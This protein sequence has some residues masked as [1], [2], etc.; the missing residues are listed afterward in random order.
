MEGGQRFVGRRRRTVVVVIVVVAAANTS[1]RIAIAI[2]VAVGSGT[3]VNLGEIRVVRKFDQA[4][5]ETEES[6]TFPLITECGEEGCVHWQID[7]F[8]LFDD[9]WG[10][11]LDGYYRGG[12]GLTCRTTIVVV[13]AVI[14]V[15]VVAV[16]VVRSDG[17]DELWWWWLL[18]LGRRGMELVTAH[19][20]S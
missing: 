20:L 16:V 13:T 19:S 1:S 17:G 3:H 2:A 6:D 5:F 9:W 11:L 7:G 15:A 4:L 10:W 12:N 14:V 8:V 18:L